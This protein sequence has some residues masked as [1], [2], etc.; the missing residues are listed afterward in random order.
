MVS[1]AGSTH[2]SSVSL[3]PTGFASDRSLDRFRVDPTLSIRV[4][5]TRQDGL[6]YETPLL[7]T[8][9]NAN[10]PPTALAGGPYV[11]NE[12]VGVTLSGS[13]LDQDTDAILSY[14]WDL[15]YDGVAFQVDATTANPTVSY[16]DGP[17]VKT[18]A[19][20][21][22]DNGLPLQ[23]SA[24]VTATVTVNNVAPIVDR[25][26]ASLNGS[27]NVLLTNTGT[28]SDVPADTVTLE[29]SL[30]SVVKN[31]NGTWSW[32][33][34][35]TTAAVNQVVTITAY[36]EDDGTISTTF[37]ITVT[38]AV[39][40]VVNRQVFYN[41]AT[42]SLFGN[43]SGNPVSSIDPTKQAL[44]P[45]QAASFAN[46]TNYVRG[47]NGIVVDIANAGGLITQPTFSSP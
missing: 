43:G 45:G 24:I 31:P 40:G 44:L 15:D 13:G 29:A 6:F 47:L 33:Y 22:T 17:M 36:D 10:D 32:S 14:E 11:T 8:V 39:A 28:W 9:N 25:D 21:V 18:V 16:P 12:G 30:G 41:N 37:T 5:T 19:L 4:R 2:N 46:V 23:T 20:R 3:S 35:P 27:V 26:N 42:G 7:V 38:G 34:L 1:G